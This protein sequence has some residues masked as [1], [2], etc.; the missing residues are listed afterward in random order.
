M[1]SNYWHARIETVGAP[2]NEKGRRADFGN[3]PVTRSHRLGLTEG[4][5]GVAAFELLATADPY[6]DS[7]A[8]CE[9]SRGSGLARRLGCYSVEAISGT[10]RKN[11]ECLPALFYAR[12]WSA[13][14]SAEIAQ[15]PIRHRRFYGGG[16]GD[17]STGNQAYM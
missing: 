14:G 1:C 4:A 11:L 16:T 7:F 2:A 17:F 10:A 9:C 15:K 8:E 5:L 12:A 13:G 3:A 6:R